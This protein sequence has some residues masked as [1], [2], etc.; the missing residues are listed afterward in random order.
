MKISLEPAA[1]YNR[2]VLSGR[3][4][5][6]ET[7]AFRDAVGPYMDEG[8]L[9]LR[10]NL[11]AVNFV[12]SSALAELVR[13]MKHCAERGSSFAVEQPS[14]PV[15]VILELTGLDRAFSIMV[16]IETA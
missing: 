10:V 5:A 15:A 4:D 1:D 11:A 16:D 7:D 2:A 9:P 13:A 8:E 12:D 14:T 6:H 3:F